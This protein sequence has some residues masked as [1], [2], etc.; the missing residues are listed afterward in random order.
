MKLRKKIFSQNDFL[1]I[2]P[3]I[4]DCEAAAAVHGR[5][6]RGQGQA[7]RRHDLHHPLQPRGPDLHLPGMHLIGH[8]LGAL[9]N[10]C[11]ITR[12]IKTKP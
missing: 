12:P 5:D 7:P 2:F 11:K 3:V 8:S 4:G 9:R 10:R 1:M 6:Q